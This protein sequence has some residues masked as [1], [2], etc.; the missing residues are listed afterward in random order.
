VS[1]FEVVATITA[2]FFAVGIV[3]GFLIVMAIPGFRRIGGAGGQQVPPHS[4]P[5][6]WDQ[7][8]PG[9]PGEPVP[10][11]RQEP[12]DRDDYPWWPGQL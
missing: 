10:A 8:G 1:A 9:P 12:D 7:L 2:V 6:P 11:P 3:V 5:D 4:H